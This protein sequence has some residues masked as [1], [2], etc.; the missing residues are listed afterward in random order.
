LLLLSNNFFIILILVIE[1][2]QC[3]NRSS[4]ADIITISSA[5]YDKTNLYISKSI[6]LKPYRIKCCFKNH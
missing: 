5:H 3:L 2:K 6:P 1:Q 4:V